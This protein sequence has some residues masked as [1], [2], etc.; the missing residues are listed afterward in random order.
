MDPPTLH[1]KISYH[2]S[3]FVW[4]TFS[5]HENHPCFPG[6]MAGW[7]KLTDQGL[8]FLQQHLPQHLYLAIDGWLLRPLGGLGRG[9]SFPNHQQGF[10][11]FNI[12]VKASWWIWSLARKIDTAGR[13]FWGHGLVLPNSPWLA[14]GRLQ[15]IAFIARVKSKKHLFYWKA[16]VFG[17]KSKNFLGSWKKV[18]SLL[19]MMHFVG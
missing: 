3:T 11:T 2:T 14:W 6:G 1:D 15:A 19:G 9:G 17:V 10:S 13:I 8:E 12:S 7:V 18:Y 5:T 4:T 16:F